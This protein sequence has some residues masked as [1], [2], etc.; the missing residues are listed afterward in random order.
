[1]SVVA[2][3]GAGDLGGTLAST[4]AGRERVAEVRLID[5]AAGVAGGKALDILQAGPVESSSTRVS[6]SAEI[7]AADEAAVIVLA[8]EV[9]PPVSEW[10]G[11]AALALVRRIRERNA[12]A[13][14]VCA[15]ASQAWLIAHAVTELGVPATHITG[16]APFALAGALR[17]LVA[18]ELNGSAQDVSLTLAGTP[19]AHV[20][21]PWQSASVAGTA[22]EALLDPARLR[23]IDSKVRYLWPPGPYALASAAARFAEGLIDGSRQTFCGFVAAEGGTRGDTAGSVAAARPQRLERG[24]VRPLDLPELTAHQRLAL[25]AVLRR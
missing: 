4:L 7:S 16:S 13:P 22:L 5:R 24:A 12:R 15:G 20:V 3:F 17:A 18:L 9:G 10:Q 6:A 8:D 19:P 11:E 21:V 2:I 1:M 23:R 25:D 14:I